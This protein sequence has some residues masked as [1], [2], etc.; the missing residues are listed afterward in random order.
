MAEQNR[1]NFPP[2][3]FTR[4]GKY[5]YTVRELTRTDASWDADKRTY[6]VEVTVTGQGA[7]LRASVIYPDGFPVF[8]N[9]RARPRFPA[10]RCFYRCL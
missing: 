4:P 6:C 9:R 1:F 10:G 5:C 2:L 8:V 3:Y 7:G